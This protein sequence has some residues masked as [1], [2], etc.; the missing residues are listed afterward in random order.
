MISS[1]QTNINLNPSVTGYISIYSEILA[2]I[3]TDIHFLKMTWF[4]MISGRQI[5]INLNPSVAGFM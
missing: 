5:N 2:Y 3:S 1:R 4:V